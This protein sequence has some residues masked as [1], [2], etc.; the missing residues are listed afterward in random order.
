M[1]YVH[2]YTALI[3]R[4]RLRTLREYTESHHIIPQCL[5][6][7]DD[8]NNLVELTPEEHYVAHLLLVKIYPENRKLIHAAVMMTVNGNG[9]KRNNKLYGWLRRRHASSISDMQTGTGNSQYGRYWICNQVT[10]DVVRISS[11]TDIP[12][13]WVRGKTLNT[14]CR[15]CGNNTG[16][17]QRTYCSEHR[18]SPV[19]PTSAMAKGSDSAKK[20]AEYCRARPKEQHPQY[21][22]RWVNNAVIQ[23]MVPLSELESLLIT[24]WKK[25]KLRS[26]N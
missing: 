4:A 8:V 14:C 5:M 11:G 2:H 13:G 9:H 15:V 24:G 7:S 23:Q 12:S 22:K 20:L 21:G 16:S 17:R 18:P 3:E 10:G 19:P 1:N 25:G 26:P 6:G